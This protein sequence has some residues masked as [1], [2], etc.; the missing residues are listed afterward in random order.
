MST[1]IKISL[2][3]SVLAIIVIIGY[4]MN[5]TGITLKN[6]NKDKTGTI[7]NEVKPYDTEYVYDE[8]IPATA[9]KVVLVEGEN[10]LDYTYDGLTYV[11]ISD[12]KNEVVKVGSGKA[13]EYKGRLT[14]YGPDCPGCSSVGNVSCK[15]KEGTKHSLIYDGIYYNDS[16]YGPLRI[17]AADNSEFP[18]GTVIKVDNG[19]LDEF[20]GIV[21]DTGSTMRKAWNEGVVWIDL[22][23]SSQKEALT[24][25]ATSL[26]TNFSVQ[27]WGF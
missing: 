18:C 3:I 8:N 27:R 17:L 13:G 22:A 12:S 23:F 7:I 20:Y 24:G 26:N 6:P 5:N 21:L 14:G 1:K 4:T 10:G 16:T 9:D 25:H 2:F 15:T 19:I 11:H